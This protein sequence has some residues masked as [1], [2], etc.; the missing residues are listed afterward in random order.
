MKSLAELSWIPTEVGV[1]D[2]L[3]GAALRSH[4]ASQQEPPDAV[5]TPLKSLNAACRDSGGG[6]GIPRPSDVKIGGATGHGKTNLMENFA[7]T[8]I[9]HGERVGCVS[10]EMSR[11]QLATRLYA[12]LTGSPIREIEPGSFVSGTAKSVERMV[13]EVRERTGGSFITH[14]EPVFEIEKVEDL[15]RYFVEIHGCTYIAVDYIQLVRARDAQS[16]Y[17]EVT[18]VSD[19]IREF[20]KRYGVI[21]LGLSQLNR[22]TSANYA[23]SPRA[24]G[25]IGSSRLENDADLVLILDHSRFERDEGGAKTW[26][27][28]SKN[29]SGP[30]GEIPIRW[31]YRTLRIREALPDEED[32]WPK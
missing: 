7:A 23:D 3:D 32:L 12:I 5:P 22:A 24:Q 6:I 20:G 10:L 31:D 4:M 2:L 15:M 11:R 1:V 29:R 19:T 13:A 27:L 30:T 17:R 25:M 28:V 8:A 26:L 16:F 21:T 14:E 9:E 18:N